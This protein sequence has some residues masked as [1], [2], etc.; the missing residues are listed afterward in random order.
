MPVLAGT[1]P[2]CAASSHSTGTATNKQE[3]VQY[4]QWSSASIS[5]IPAGI[6]CG[7]RQ[8]YSSAAVGSGATSPACSPSCFQYPKH[9]IC[10][11]SYHKAVTVQRQR[12]IP[13]GLLNPRAVWLRSGYSQHT[14]SHHTPVP[15]G[16]DKQ[17]ADDQS[18]GPALPGLVGGTASFCQ[19]IFCLF[20][21]LEAVTRT[22][23]PCRSGCSKC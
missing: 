5:Q 3:H 10:T 16:V 12:H 7:Q 11:R 2:S 9:L 19:N 14:A 15:T 21:L 4:S 8:A 6:C 17:K 23:C 22:S 1:M 18:S 13:L 20:S